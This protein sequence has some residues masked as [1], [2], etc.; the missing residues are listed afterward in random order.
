MDF[1]LV[2]NFSLGVTALLTNIGWKS[3]I[4]L[5]RGQFDPKF[6][7]ERVSP[8]IDV[9]NV[10]GKIKNVKKRKKRGKNKKRLKRYKNVD[11]TVI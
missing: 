1:L 8:T 4:S 10:G 5:Q 9:K 2:L 6:Q 3:A 11:A 7:V